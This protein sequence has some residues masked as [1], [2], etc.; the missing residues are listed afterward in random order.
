MR[1]CE[2]CGYEAADWSVVAASVAGA[3]ESRVCDA[4]LEPCQF[5]VLSS[6]GR[7]LRVR[8]LSRFP[9]ISVLDGRGEN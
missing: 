5:D 8:S 6:G 9:A 4:C 1:V 2:R 7:V 3:F